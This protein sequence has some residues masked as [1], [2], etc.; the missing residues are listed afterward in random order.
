MSDSTITLLMQ[1]GKMAVQEW[2]SE[3]SEWK[4]VTYIDTPDS[5]SPCEE[6]CHPPEKE[7]S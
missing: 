3:Q 7:K 2:P 6:L 5:R 1:G 4:G